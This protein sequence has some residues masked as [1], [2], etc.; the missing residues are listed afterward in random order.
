MPSVC[1]QGRRGPEHAQRRHTADDDRQE[2]LP[3]SVSAPKSMWVDVAFFFFS[4]ATLPTKRRNGA[5]KR[6]P[7]PAH[8]MA[9]R[10]LQGLVHDLSSGS[11][12]QL[13]AAKQ[14]R[15]LLS[16]RS[17]LPSIGDH[18]CVRCVTHTVTRTYASGGA[19]AMRAIRPSW[20]GNTRAVAP[21]ATGTFA[22]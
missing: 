3:L 20:Q 13:D 12:K 9:S 11:R 10:T 5:M 6:Q 21:L 7:D 1:V 19:H 18:K 17:A 2:R 4:G 15:A 22:R 16:A 14:I 8:T